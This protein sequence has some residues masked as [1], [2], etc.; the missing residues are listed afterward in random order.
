[1]FVARGFGQIFQFIGAV[2]FRHTA[3]AHGQRRFRA[4]LPHQQR[5]QI[6]AHF[7]IATLGIEFLQSGHRFA[8]RRFAL[9]RMRRPM[10]AF[11]LNIVCPCR[12]RACPCQ[13]HAHSD[14]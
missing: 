13:G 4:P 5:N 9:A 6:G 14:A 8:Q 11:G 7:G 1:M 12:R 10:L 2:I 3:A